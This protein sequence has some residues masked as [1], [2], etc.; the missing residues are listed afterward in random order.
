MPVRSIATYLVTGIFVVLAM[1]FVA[2]PVGLG[3]AASIWPRAD[4]S[5]AVQSVN[6]LHKGDRLPIPSISVGKQLAPR[7]SPEVPV[8]CEA[9]FSPLSA[10][11]KTN[12]NGQNLSSVCVV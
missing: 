8:G 6:R 11:T 3:L 1:D 5:V 4:E 2:P 7:Q 12:F 9:V 10:S